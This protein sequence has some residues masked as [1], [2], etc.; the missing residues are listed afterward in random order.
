MNTGFSPAVIMLAASCESTL[1]HIIWVNGR[2][3]LALSC[4]QPDTKFAQN[5]RSQE[6]L[7]N[8]TAMGTFPFHK[9][10]WYKTKPSKEIFNKYFILSYSL[11][12]CCEHT[13]STLKMHHHEYTKLVNGFYIQFRQSFAKETFSYDEHLKS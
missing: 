1:Q 7:S 9:S 8:Q 11:T 13:K 3:A 12:I 10:F 2:P 6:G 5:I 4:K